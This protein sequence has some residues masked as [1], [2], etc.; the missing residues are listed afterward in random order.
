VRYFETFR[1]QHQTP[2]LQLAHRPVKFSVAIFIISGDFMPLGLAM[3]TDLMCTSGNKF[4][5]NNAE[6]ASALQQ[7]HPAM[8][9]LARLINPHAPFTIGHVCLFQRVSDFSQIL[10]PVPLDH[11]AIVFAHAFIQQHG[12]QY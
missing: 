3:N 11:S 10:R 5:S 12:L 2:N 8:C 1:V 6:L 9:R 4:H 7:M